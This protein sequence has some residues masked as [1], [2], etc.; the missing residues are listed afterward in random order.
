MFIFRIFINILY[1]CIISSHLNG[2]LSRLI[3]SN[4]NTSTFP[5]SN[6][7]KGNECYTRQNYK[8]YYNTYNNKCTGPSGCTFVNPLACLIEEPIRIGSNPIL[9]LK[10]SFLIFIWIC[11]DHHSFLPVDYVVFVCFHLFVFYN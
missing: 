5:T 10:I 1:T 11:N 9:K 7:L 4:K 8:S 2:L 3:L 6:T